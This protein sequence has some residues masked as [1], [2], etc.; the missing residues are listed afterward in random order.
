MRPLAEAA[1]KRADA[2]ERHYETSVTYIT[3][4]DASCTA[5]T[6]M[7]GVIVKYSG[8]PAGSN[9]SDVVAVGLSSIRTNASV[10]HSTRTMYVWEPIGFAVLP[11][12]PE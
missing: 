4:P 12:V 3:P 10:V 5:D 9:A 2:T 7:P 8:A 11:A 6:L 1:T